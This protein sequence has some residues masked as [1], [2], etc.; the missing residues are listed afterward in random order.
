MLILT[1]VNFMTPWFTKNSDRSSKKN[2]L[3]IRSGLTKFC[4]KLDFLPANDGTQRKFLAELYL[5]TA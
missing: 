4:S 3:M 1:Q 2:H 5:G